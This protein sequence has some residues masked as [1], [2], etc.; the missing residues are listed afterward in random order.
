MAEHS[1]HPFIGVDNAEQHAQGRGLARSVRAEH[2]IDR[3]LAHFQINAI[4]GQSP[5]KAFDQ[6]AR[7]NRER[8][9]I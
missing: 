1:P 7:F 3:T 6:P 5:V 8:T 2:A 9:I 4:N